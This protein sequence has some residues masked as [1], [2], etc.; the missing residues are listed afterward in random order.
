ME[1]TD[2]R[3]SEFLTEEDVVSRPFRVE[4]MKF[5][6]NEWGEPRHLLLPGGLIAAP[7]FEEA[8]LCFLNGE[9]IACVLLS[10]V[11]LEHVLAG[12]LKMAGRDDLERAGFEKLLREALSEG[13]ISGEEFEAF[14]SL[15]ER[16]NPYVHSR[17]PTDAGGLVRRM[18]A[19]DRELE[20]LFETDARLAVQTMFRLLKRGPYGFNE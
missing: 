4:R 12:A 2:D 3:I 16:R 17:H 1:Y 13:I 9:F 15:R 18:T 8:R 20:E 11:V 7:A 14:D 6:L 19:E 5:L 10:Q